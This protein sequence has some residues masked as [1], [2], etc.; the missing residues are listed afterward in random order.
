MF[1]ELAVT[2][3]I[4]FIYDGQLPAS[5]GDGRFDFWFGIGIA[6]AAALML[7]IAYLR[8]RRHV[9]R[10]RGLAGGP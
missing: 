6:A 8:R 9:R 4:I 3:P 2:E 10:Q 1:P 7:L 5:H